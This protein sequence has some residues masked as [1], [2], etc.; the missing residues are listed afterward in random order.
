MAG[1]LKG[2]R[3]T[4]KTLM[5]KCTL[6]YFI[7]GVIIG[8]IMLLY[9]FSNSDFKWNIAD[10]AYYGVTAGLFASL[11]MPFVMGVVG[12]FHSFMLWYPM[13]WVYRKVFN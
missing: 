5:K 1:N 11:F 13:V 10:N 4:V 8:V 12:F 9:S 2:S 7:I 3:I 6:L